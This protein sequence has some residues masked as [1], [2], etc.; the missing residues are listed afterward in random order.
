[1]QDL[2]DRLKQQEALVADGATGTM[3][4][5]RGLEAGA[6]PERMN[7]DRPEVLTASTLKPV[8]ISSKRTPSAPLPSSSRSTRSQTEPKKSTSALSA[9]FAR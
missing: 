8:Q 3:L 9:P 2:L 7:I 4:L 5:Q 6:C 1:M